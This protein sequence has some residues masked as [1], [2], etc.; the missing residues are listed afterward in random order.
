MKRWVTAIASAA[1]II[2]LAF[3]QGIPNWGRIIICIFGIVCLATLVYCEIKADF[4]NQRV[5]TSE[6]EIQTAMMQIIKSP[7][8]ICIMSRDLSWVTDEIKDCIKR[9]HDVLIFAEK[10][11]DLTKELSTVGVQIK[12]YGKYGFEPKTRFTIIGYNKNNPQV[13]IANTQRTIRKKGK[14]KHIIYE[15]S[16][17]NYTQDE[18]I[19]SLAIDMMNLC[20]VVSEGANKCLKE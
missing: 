1:S 10:E 18:W 5:C 16:S 6:A 13:A 7:G 17:G 4:A 14:M 2:G 11:T 9:K 3:I 8:K 19:N 15:T 12:Y 20:N